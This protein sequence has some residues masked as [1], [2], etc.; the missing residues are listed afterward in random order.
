MKIVKV[1]HKITSDFLLDLYEKAKGMKGEKKKK[2][3]KQ[4]ELLSQHKGE[5]LV[6]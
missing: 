3:L 2:L 1:K 6:E 5:N 4:I